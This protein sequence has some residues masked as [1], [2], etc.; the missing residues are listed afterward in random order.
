MKNKQIITHSLLLIFLFLS[1]SF[2]RAQENI[3]VVNYA[4]PKD[5]EIGG[6][7]ISGVQFLD[8]NILI[9]LSGLQVGDVISVPGDE[10][11][12]A[13]QNLWNQGLFEE[14]NISITKIQDKLIFLNIHLVERPRL[15]KYSFSGVKKAEA[16]DLRDE[17]Q[18]SRGDVVTEEFLLRVKH[19][20]KMH[21]I[22]KAFLNVEVNIKQIADTSSSKNDVELKIQIDK[23]NKVKIQEIK[24]RGNNNLESSK[25]KRTMKE[26]K[27]KSFYRVWKRSKYIEGEFKSDLALVIAKYHELGYR[28]V[29]IVKDTFCFC[30]ENEICMDIEINEGNK[31]FF[32]DITWSGNTKYTDEKLSEVLGIKKGDIYNQ[33]VLDANLYMNMEGVDISS[34]YLDDGYLFFQVNP[35]EKRVYND[36]IDLVMQIYEGKQAVINK[37]TITGNTR[38]NDHV[39]LR[40]IRTKPGELFN[41]SDITRTLRELA[42][43]RYFNQEKLN[44]NPVPNPAD[45]TV[46]IEYIVEETSTDQ[47]ELSGGWGMG[48][49]VGTFGVSFNNF[50]MRNIFKGEYWSP[51]PSGDGQK[52]SIRAQ[53]NGTYYQSYN[54]SFTEPWLGGKKPNSFTVSVYHSVQTNGIKKK[55]DGTTD[56]YG[57]VLERQEIQINGVTVG[58]GTRLKWPDDYFT[59]YGNV[60]Y[61]NYN[62]NNYQSSFSYGDGNS[63]NFSVTGMLNRSSVDAPIY[64]RSGS[65]LL[66]SVQFTPPYSLLNNKD[67]SQLEDSEKFKWLEYHKWK[68]NASFF[69]KLAGNLVLNTRTKFGFLG[70]YNGDLEIAPF[71]RFY[72]GGDGLSGFALDGR[73]LIGMRGYGNNT[74]TPR[75]DNGY[76][77]GTIYTKYTLELRYPVSMNPMATIYV[78]GFLE[79]G[80]TW[81]R[82]D[83]FNPYD[84]KRSAGV[85]VR[86]YMPM[87]GILG[88][89]WGYGFDNVPG[90]PGANKGQ[91]HFSI[92]QSI[93]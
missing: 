68:F 84:V 92:N 58:L 1:P 69:T 13:I 23:K 88:L 24:I 27:Q 77:G 90:I 31:Y 74:L 22:D 67:Y 44:V 17:L 21:Y 14:I 4:T 8:N 56:D 52:L 71:E 32:G 6:I 60:A 12:K 89:D 2:I 10:I 37:V 45:G 5:Y 87:F 93:D 55:E 51:L 54:M 11:T 34:L 81:Q 15:S 70:R 39:V 18:I 25:I 16:D 26:T 76:I 43:L 28:D 9:L 65:D 33:T 50:S 80:N 29:E 72:L 57:N 82:F 75:D 62:L 78:L 66:L 91:F 61:Q 38:T 20:I 73:E 49:I 86:L 59:L 19:K 3:D 48:Q 30:G 53:S 64:P 47:I 63:N 42:Q 35:T 83:N 36:T 46:A 79:A 85:G 40:E 41:R 7:T